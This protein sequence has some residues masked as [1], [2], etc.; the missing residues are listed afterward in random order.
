MIPIV[1][2][3]PP[4]EITRRLR[5]EAAHHLPGH[6]GECAHVHGHSWQAWV[7]VRGQQQAEGDEAGMVLEMGRLADYFRSDVEPG[8]DHR[9]LNDTL[10]DEFLPPT[11]ENVARFLLAV[12]RG[13]GFPVVRVTVRET[14]NQEATAFNEDA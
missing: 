11:T 12:F 1:E 5:F 8:L 7:T 3:Q 13:A 4:V 10:P 9:H 6:P 2:G 14:E